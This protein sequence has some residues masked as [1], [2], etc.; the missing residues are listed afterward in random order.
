MH[1]LQATAFCGPEVLEEIMDEMHERIKQAVFHA[2]K[3]KQQARQADS[4]R[5]ELN[6]LRRISE[7]ICSGSFAEKYAVMMDLKRRRELEEKYGQ[8]LKERKKEADAS[9]K[10]FE[11]YLGDFL[12]EALADNVVAVLKARESD[13]CNVPIA[14]KEEVDVYLSVWRLATDRSTMFGLATYEDY[15]D[16]CRGKRKLDIPDE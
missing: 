11:E 13:P 15:V 16:W 7:A 4:E 14:C 12:S 9:L 6:K 10:E 3:E 1:R 2:I 8:S 5:R